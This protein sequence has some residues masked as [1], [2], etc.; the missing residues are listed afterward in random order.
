MCVLARENLRTI[1]SHLRL[2]AS[3]ASGH[4]KWICDAKISYHPFAEGIAHRPKG[5]RPLKS[6]SNTFDKIFPRK[7]ATFSGISLKLR[8]FR[9]PGFFK[10]LK[11][12]DA[13]W[14]IGPGTVPHLKVPRFFS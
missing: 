9:V 2:L 1:R 11:I 6:D 14:I 12:S 7:S 8:R 5:R 4:K 10:F 3:A 13:Y